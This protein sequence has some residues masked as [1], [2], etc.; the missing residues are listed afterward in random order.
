MYLL[1]NILARGAMC[2][3]S[4]N[5]TANRLKFSNFVFGYIDFMIFRNTFFHI[6]LRHHQ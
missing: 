5:R 4:V 1:C 2:L 3:Q 6:D